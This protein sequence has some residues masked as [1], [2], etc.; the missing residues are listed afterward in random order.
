MLPF[1]IAYVWCSR[2]PRYA[3]PQRRKGDPKFDF[4]E[5]AKPFSEG[6]KVPRKSAGIAEDDDVHGG[7]GVLRK[8]HVCDIQSRPVRTSTDF[9]PKHFCQLDS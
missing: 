6:A 5:K 3:D 1:R 9:I 2:F 4:S 7:E 8:K